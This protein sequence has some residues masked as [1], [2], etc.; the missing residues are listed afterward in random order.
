MTREG[1]ARITAG[2]IGAAVLLSLIPPLAKALGRGEGLFE[3]IWGLL[4][5]F[6]ITTNLLVGLVFTRLAWRGRDSVG[7]VLLGGTMLA[8]VLV[9]MVFN[10]LLPALPHQTL[11]DAL[12]DRI[13][14]V[15]APIVVPL[16]WA[17]FT[18]HGRLRWTAPLLWALYPLGYIAYTFV[19]VA[20][21]PVASDGH[22]RYPYFF[23]D[24]DRFGPGTVVLNLVGISAG[25]I[26]AGLLS[27]ALDRRLA[28]RG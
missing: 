25:F 26:V 14:H 3:A 21:T 5:W 1:W 28:T 18:P 2:V 23:M 17:V 15:V 19:R 9:G 6:T 8:I 4:R 22:S 7:P 24:L 13:H 10:L 12:G 20:F 27:V 11:W 16:W